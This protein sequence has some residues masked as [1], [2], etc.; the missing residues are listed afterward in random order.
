MKNL[1]KVIASLLLLLAVVDAR[2]N[3][4]DGSIESR[5]SLE[6]GSSA[7]QGFRVGVLKPT[8]KQKFAVG[9]YANEY[10]LEAT[11]LTIGYGRIPVRQLGWTSELAYLS[12]STA[13]ASIVR[14]STNL[15]YAVNGLINIKGGFNLSTIS[16]D[17]DATQTNFTPSMGSQISIGV[18]ITKNLSAEFGYVEMIQTAT[19]NNSQTFTS[20]GGST[21]QNRIEVHGRAKESGT[22]LSLVGT[23]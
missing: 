8:L 19:Q 15:A 23:F 18:Q 17:A 14:L 11:G 6:T 4:D 16:I 22:E 12:I 20:P 7:S 13:P 21:E 5:L 3:A 1:T 2:A 10:N 9:D